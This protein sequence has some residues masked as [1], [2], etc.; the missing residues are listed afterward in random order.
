ME[1][2][3]CKSTG[4]ADN[5][6]TCPNCSADLEAYHLT[7]KIEKTSRNR[8]WFGIASSVIL[9]IIIIIWLFGCLLSGNGLKEQ[10]KT[11]NEE[12]DRLKIERQEMISENDRLKAENKKMKDQLSEINLTVAK[13]QE[14]Y[15]V[16]PGETLFIIARKVYGNGFKYHDLAKAN[17]IS[18]P[19]IILEG[20]KL[21]IHY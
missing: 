6:T 21:T 20:Q 17:N 1:C 3:V 19:N 16:Q 12:I 7:E 10:L 18:D 15:M 2:P 8:L 5:L 9:V 13:K 4:I 14:I 11:A